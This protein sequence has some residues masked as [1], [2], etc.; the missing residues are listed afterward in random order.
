MNQNVQLSLLMVREDVER[1]TA[2]LD[3]VGRKASRE[4]LLPILKEHFEPVVAEE[5]AI[6]ADHTESG[7]LVQSLSARAG[8]GD[9]P[10][11]MS[12]FSAPTATTKQLQSTWGK[13]R[14]QQ[15]KW[16]AGLKTKGRRKV[17]YGNIVHQGHRIVKRNAQGQLYDTGR[18]TTPVPFAAEAMAA[19]GEAQSEA[20]AEALLKHIWGE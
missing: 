3:G 7:A 9:R 16:A 18:M 13:G 15:R 4:E 10:G 20:A 14:W 6:L 1:F 12:V 2:F 17:F 11:T 8:P 19:V 5:K